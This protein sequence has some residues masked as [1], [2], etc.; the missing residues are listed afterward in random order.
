PRWRAPPH[1]QGFEPCWIEAFTNQETWNVGLAITSDGLACLIWPRRQIVDKRRHARSGRRHQR[2]HL[3]ASSLLLAVAFGAARA[4]SPVS[5][6]R[7]YAIEC[8]QID[9]QDMGVFSDTGEYDGGTG[10][11]AVTCYL[12]R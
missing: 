2:L 8:G 11:L 7:L 1:K 9:V 6:V 12:I 10:S 5:T 4:E 3:F